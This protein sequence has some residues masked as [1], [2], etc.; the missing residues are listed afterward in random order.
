MNLVEIWMS[1]IG[2]ILPLSATAQIFRIC[3]RKSS[4]DI[5]LLFYA[6]L[7]FCQSAWVWYGFYKDSLCIKLTN[8]LGVLEALTIFVLALNYR[9]EL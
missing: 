6:V 2:L 5:S 7:I 9:K 1:F 8:G 4:G 3:K